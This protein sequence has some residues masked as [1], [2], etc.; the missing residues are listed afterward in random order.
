M[1]YLIFPPEI[2]IKSVHTW[3]KSLDEIF[4][5][6][7]VMAISLTKSLVN[8]GLSLLRPGWVILKEQSESMLVFT[9]LD[10]EENSSSVVK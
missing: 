7:A 6:T 8:C 2:T 4:L 9:S 5:E 3:I 1:S 10:C